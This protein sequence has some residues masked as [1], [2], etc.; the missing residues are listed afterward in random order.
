MKYKKI[1]FHRNHVPDKNIR[2]VSQKYWYFVELKQC[3]PD[4]FHS[5]LK[6]IFTPLKH[7]QFES[8]VEI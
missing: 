6:H 5:A 3:V 8:P 2:S 1:Q 4:E 7:T